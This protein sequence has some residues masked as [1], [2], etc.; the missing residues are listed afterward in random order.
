MQIHVQTLISL[1]DDIKYHI[2]YMGVSPPNDNFFFD[3][4]L[5]QLYLVCITIKLCVTYIY[6]LDMTLTF[7]FF[8]KI[9]VILAWI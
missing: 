8:V 3:T 4:D 2:W 6:D 1:L 5:S 7:D 9:I